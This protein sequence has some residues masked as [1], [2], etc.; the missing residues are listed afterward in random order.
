MSGPRWTDGKW[1]ASGTVVR[2]FGRGEVARCPVPQDGGTVD[3]VANAKLIAAA[4]DLYEALAYLVE[5]DRGTE[6][7]WA[8]ADRALAKARGE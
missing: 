5:N 2:V 1:T 4:P 6:E 7:T 3:C 8:I